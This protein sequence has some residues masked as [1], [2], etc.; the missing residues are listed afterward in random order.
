M[1]VRKAALPIPFCL[2]LSLAGWFAAV[3]ATPS[4]AASLCDKHDGCDDKDKEKDK[5]K[6]PPVTTTVFTTTTVPGP[7]TTRTTTTSVTVTQP[8]GTTTLQQNSQS[9]PTTVT[10]PGQQTGQTFTV[11]GVTTQAVPVAAPPSVTVKPKTRTITM[12]KKQV[13]RVWSKKLHRYVKMTRFE[14]VRV[15]ILAPQA[16][17]NPSV[18]LAAG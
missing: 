12:Y 3:A 16:L 13:V 6:K 7:T 15:K 4:Q 8:G 2:A 17:Q 11:Q 10:I 9:P 1:R 14:R 5:D 18:P